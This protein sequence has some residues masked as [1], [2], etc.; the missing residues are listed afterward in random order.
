MKDIFSAVTNAIKTKTKSCNPILLGGGGALW[1]TSG[2][3]S[4]TPR[5]EKQKLL[6]L[7]DF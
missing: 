3:S 2:F 4:A 7:D 1:P 5:A 6:K